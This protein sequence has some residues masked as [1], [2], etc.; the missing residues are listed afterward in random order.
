MP[1]YSLIVLT[2]PVEGQEAEFN[3]WYSDRHL[4]DVLKVPGVIGAQRF[5]LAAEQADPAGAQRWRYLAI[6][7]CETDDLAGLIA[8][9]KRRAGTDAMPFSPAMAGDVHAAYFEPMTPLRVEA[10]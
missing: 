8:E 4:D 5:K 2:N 6:Y 1:S 7:H 3:A 10:R 9:V